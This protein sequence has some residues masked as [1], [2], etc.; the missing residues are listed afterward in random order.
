M[1][2]ERKYE[3]PQFEVVVINSVDI[4]TSSDNEADWGDL[5]GTGVQN[6]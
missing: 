2:E 1:I 5:N 3:K 4:I 6:T